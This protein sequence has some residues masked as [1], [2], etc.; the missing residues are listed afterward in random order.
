[1]EAVVA[2]AE[3]PPQAGA[4]P[5]LLGNVKPR[6]GSTGVTVAIKVPFPRPSWLTQDE[7]RTYIKLTK[8]F[9]MHPPSNPRPDEIKEMNMY[10]VRKKK[11]TK[12]KGGWG[13]S[14]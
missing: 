6:N 5:A 13:V 14:C 7:N 10:K 9:T 2:A 12:L 3:K 4:H 11:C 8:K 1:M